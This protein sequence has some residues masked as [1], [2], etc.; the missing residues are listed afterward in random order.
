MIRRY[1][2]WL[3][4]RWPAGRVEPLP[5]IDPEGRTRVP[6]VYVVGD[7]T[8]VP[9]LKFAI[10]TG[11]QAVHRAAAE[12]G[13]QAGSRSQETVPLVIL[14]AGVSG[15]SAALE[16]RRL[17]I[18]ARVFEARRPL[19]T[20]H[21]YPAGK[22]I[23]AYPKE[24]V[25]DGPL[26]VHDTVKEALIE[27]LEARTR[28]VPVDPGDAERVERSGED[29]V[30]HFA[31]RPPV[32]AR[33]VLVALGRSGH[34]R[35][36]GV[37]GDDLPKVHHRLFDPKDHAGRR[38][39]VVGGGDSALEAAVALADAGA[40][41]TL[42]H[43]RDRFTRPKEENQA[44]LQARVE[45]GRIVL[46][47]GRRVREVDDAGV[48]LD[49]GESL[50]CDEVFALIGRE[51]PLAFFR[52]SRLPV[53]GERTP[54][55]WLSLALFVLFCAALYD[56]KSGG[57]LHRLA[58][59]AGLFPFSLEA[60]AAGVPSQSLARVLLISASSP[61][62]WYTLVYSVLVVVFG[63]RRIR[64]RK[65][66]Y[67]TAQTITLMAVQVLPLFLLPE[68]ILPYL[69]AK[70]LLPTGLADAL[71]PR[72]DYGHGRE[73]WRAY[74]FVLAWPLFVYNALTA[75]PLGAWLVIGA[76]QTFVLIPAAIYFFGK[77]AYC[78]W[79][80]SCGALA[81]TLGD[82]HRH[83]MPHGP[84]T[85]RL[86]MA[87]QL[88]LLVAFLLLALR[89]VAWA[90]PESGLDRYVFTALSGGPLSYKWV[91]DVF[92]AGV[93]G[94]GVYFWLSGRVWCRF[95]CPLAA[96]MHIYARFSRFRILARKERCISCGE[97][98]RYC[99]QGIDV[100]AFASRGEAMQDPECVRCS[101]C[102]AVCPT[103]VLEFGRVDGRGEA[104]RD[105]LR[106]SPLAVLSSEPAPSDPEGHLPGPH[107]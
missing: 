20:L 105:R 92:L 58:Q 49:D 69:D 19:H 40:E 5:E 100:M 75:E 7:L 11:A 85:N 96:L 57:V 54:R 44:T 47:M 95:F 27:S 70:G 94:Y 50:P 39:V 81:E 34:H 90:L 37:P 28:S 55:W 30:V 76:L 32:R 97:C 93:V 79:V 15:L 67:V 46:R 103:G 62:F 42:V 89:I 29:L 53:I 83:K 9:L 98:T 18:E 63:V 36:L 43:R 21:E 26:E 87:G 8:G 72:V 56:W 84:G 91:V 88:I 16:A 10:Q 104:R 3:H 17:G 23:F 82:A 33:A 38:V 78:G 73:F 2:Q 52:R 22:P 6:G 66:P 106:A 4:G 68:V 65:T 35:R 107:P 101:A 102:I 24:M 71:F 13:L 14:G 51:P 25:P 74:G 99:H 41:V 12:R 64:R 77:G 86:N 1:Y 45:S 60:L 31:D 59:E 48:T 80:C 61:S